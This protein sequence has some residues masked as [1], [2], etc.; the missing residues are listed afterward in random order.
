MG[1][2]SLR[3]FDSLARPAALAAPAS[4]LDGLLAV[5]AALRTSPELEP[6]LDAVAGCVSTAIG[7]GTVAINLYR[8][9]YDDFE[10]LAVHGNAAARRALLGTTSPS[11]AWARLVDPRFLRRGVYVL[12]AGTYDWD[13]D[14]AITYVPEIAPS[15]DP[16]AW[17]ADDAMFVPVRSS[18]GDTVAILS[19]DEPLDGR[20]PSDAKLD[21]LAAIAAQAGLAIEAAQHAE[22]ARRHRAAVQHL[23]RVA[24][25][26]TSERSREGIATAVCE[27]IREALGFD[28]VTV[29]LRDADAGLYRISAT[30]GWPTGAAPTGTWALDDI[31]GLLDER[32][33]REGCVLLTNEEACA[34]TPPHMHGIYSSQCNGSGPFG[35][36]HHWLLVPMHGED[37]ELIGVIWPEDPV[38]RLL[39]TQERLGTLRAFGNQAASALEAA[40]AREQLAYLAEHDPLT[41]LRNRRN[42]REAIDAVVAAS[43]SEGVAL[44]VMDADTFKRVNDELGYAT[45]DEVLLGVAA[46]LRGALV[47][48]GLAARLGGEEFALVLPRVG[49]VGARLIAEAVRRSVAAKTT[50]P[51]GLT[52]SVGIAVTGDDVRNAED[53]MR[54]GTR[55]L[56]AA[57]RLGRDRVVLYDRTSIDA[58]L[59]ALDRED[60]RSA[61]HLSAVL[62]LAETLDL[63]DAGTAR[64]SQ[65]V[66]RYAEVIAGRLGFA[67]DRVERLRI[68]GLLHDIG[69]IGVADA[70]LH[71]PSKLDDEEWNEI[72]RHPEVGDRILRHAGLTDI[73]GW[74]LAHHERWD[75]GGYP[76][77]LA[78]EEIAVEARILSVADAYEAMT[79]SRPYRPAPL[80]DAAAREELQRCA[81]SQFDPAV[82]SA[83][84]ATAP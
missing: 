61:H 50:V 59:E 8:P 58:L 54:A 2:P 4:P 41:G 53:L 44:A 60:T 29:V 73:A 27:G 39:P 65:T 12:P 79:A 1:A 51:W 70:I 20:R 33:L 75:G 35:W 13:G 76:Q 24:S 68:A 22:A 72:R 14:S 80:D 17:D 45:G 19:V 81:G 21:L 57:K 47:T 63:R 9:A 36:D 6:M 67:A 15:D 48:D 46:E 69:K 71:K 30:A 3:S 5:A 16:D 40:S 10:A 62:L 34:L 26:L 32:H 43:G 64:H 37:G 78:G 84:L 56:F 77:G 23:L 74:V 55:A 82:V 49:A 18:T 38:D 31:A 25:R 42:L 83:F 7:F 66:S 52:L 11:A 28:R